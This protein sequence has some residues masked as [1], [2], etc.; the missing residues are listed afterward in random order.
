V[1]SRKGLAEFRPFR[2]VVVV[3]FLC[4]IA[5]IAIG[6]YVFYL[7]QRKAIKERQLQALSAVADMKA[8]TIATWLKGR[9]GNAQVISR[10]SVIARA[11]LGWFQSSESGVGMDLSGWMAALKSQYEYADVL[12]YDGSGRMRLST[13]A[14]AWRPF[15]SENAAVLQAIK[16]GREV[17]TDLDYGRHRNVELTITTPLLLPPRNAVVGAVVIR[18]DARHFLFPQIQAWPTP[19]PTAETLLVRREKDH[20]VYLN[21]LRHRVDAALALKIPLSRNEIS[22]VQLVNGGDGVVEGRDYRG[23]DVLAAARHVR[24]TDWFVIAKVDAAEIYDPIRERAWFL[25]LTTALLISALVTLMGLLWRHRA[26][27]FYRQRYQ[28]ERTRRVLAS[29]F[30]HL[31]KY[32]NDLILLMDEHSNITEANDRAVR[33][34]GY[35][36]E[37]LIGM[38]C[39]ALRDSTSAASFDEQWKTVEQEG[40]SIFEAVHLRSDGSTFPVE[41]SARIIDIEGKRFRQGHYRAQASGGGA[42]AKRG[43]AAG[44]PRQRCRWRVPQGL[45]E[46]HAAGKCGGAPLPRQISRCRNR[47][48]RRR[49]L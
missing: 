10:N 45:P 21:D 26:A 48:S 6:G 38:P 19:S 25:F 44:H 47:Q 11:A 16:G 7:D 29:H 37:Q 24:G 27:M 34:Y 14:S 22:S 17:F 12:L 3:V 39:C 32:A 2:T 23:V 41:V 40:G 46:P 1:S 42:E 18:I 43:P 30:E 4:L 28:A 36:R 35:P 20:V 15:E 33:C 49:V 31:Y 13:S 9:L 5:G 8:D